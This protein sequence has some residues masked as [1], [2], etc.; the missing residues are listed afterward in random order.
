M[1]KHNVS[2]AFSLKILKG[3]SEDKRKMRSVLKIIDT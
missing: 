1:L 2:T 3:I